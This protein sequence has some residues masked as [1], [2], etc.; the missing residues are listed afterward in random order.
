MYYGLPSWYY[1]AA[2]SIG[3]R[4]APDAGPPSDAPRG[5][6]GNNPSGP[7]GT[8]DST[9]DPFPQNVPGVTNVGSGADESFGPANLNNV[10]NNVANLGR[11]GVPITPIVPFA[12]QPS[13]SSSSTPSTEPNDESQADWDFDGMSGSNEFHFIIIS[14]PRS[15]KPGF[16][17][18]DAHD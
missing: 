4:I 5:S 1:T 9:S 3:A 13:S 17:P 8:A 15:D 14:H 16:P 2:T 18:P 6:Q 12:S 11:Q 10:W 7:A